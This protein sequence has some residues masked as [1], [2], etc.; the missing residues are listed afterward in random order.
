MHCVV[1]SE[2]RYAECRC[3]ESRDAI[4]SDVESYDDRKTFVRRFLSLLTDNYD[5]EKKNLKWSIIKIPSRA[6]GRRADIE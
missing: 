1:Y 6:S 2:R 5:D 4:Q 3:A